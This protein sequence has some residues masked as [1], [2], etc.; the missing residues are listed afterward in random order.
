MSLE[1]LAR[2]DV[3]SSSLTARPRLARSRLLMWT[4]TVMMVG[5]V[6]LG[7]QCNVSTIDADCEH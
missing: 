1:R 7:D 3:D 4:M 6:A 5:W 2:F